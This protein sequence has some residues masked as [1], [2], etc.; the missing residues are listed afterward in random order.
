MSTWR[1]CHLPWRASWRLL[2]KCPKSVSAASGLLVP[3]S[4]T[5]DLSCCDLGLVS[6]GGAL[7][8][9]PVKQVG[10]TTWSLTNQLSCFPL[11]YYWFPARS[12]QLVVSTSHERKHSS[13][14]IALFIS[15]R[16]NEFIV[17]YKLSYLF[18][19]DQAILNSTKKQSS[20][21]ILL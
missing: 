13:L 7:V 1:Q 19:K 8:S 21:Q 17:L 4:S 20:P 15:F 18:L 11:Y 6:D 5:A 9:L 10:W 3:D 2:G 16:N 12:S 14:F